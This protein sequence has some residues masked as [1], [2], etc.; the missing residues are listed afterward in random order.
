[1]FEDNVYFAIFKFALTCLL[2]YFG[3]KKGYKA[4]KEAKENE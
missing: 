3:F 1:M 4:M 2:V